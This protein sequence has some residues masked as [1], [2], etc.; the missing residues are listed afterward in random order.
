[1]VEWKNGVDDQSSRCLLDGRDRS[2][3]HIEHVT[4]FRCANVAANDINLEM[5]VRSAH[6]DIQWAIRSGRYI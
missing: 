3:E 6:R 5:F 2:A 1:L 4:D